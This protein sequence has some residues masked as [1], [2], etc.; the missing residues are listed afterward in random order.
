MATKFYLNPN[1]NNKRKMT[2]HLLNSDI[3][4]KNYDVMESFSKSGRFI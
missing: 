4:L 1:T 2:S 3:M